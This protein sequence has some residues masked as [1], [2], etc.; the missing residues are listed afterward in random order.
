MAFQRIKTIKGKQYLYEEERWR[1]GKKIKTRSRYIGPVEL[2]KA[3]VDN[4]VTPMTD[5]QRMH[6]I[7][8]QAVEGAYKAKVTAAKEKAPAANKAEGATAKPTSSETA[9]PSAPGAKPSE[10]EPPRSPGNQPESHPPGAQEPLPD[11]S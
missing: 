10:A 4:I 3:I 6:E 7:M 8:F 9:L 1:K 2:L 11:P 5:E